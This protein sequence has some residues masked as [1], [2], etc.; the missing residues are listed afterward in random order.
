[1]Y[2]I[3]NV[4]RQERMSDLDH[5]LKT[6]LNV[7]YDHHKNINLLIILDI[8]RDVKIDRTLLPS[9]NFQNTTTVRYIKSMYKMTLCGKMYLCILSNNVYLF[10]CKGVKISKVFKQPKEQ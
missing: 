4:Y 1:M 7:L 3:L 2:N 9:Q 6:N 5:N 10:N 8:G